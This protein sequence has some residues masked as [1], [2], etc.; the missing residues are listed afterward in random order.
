M[1]TQAEERVKSRLLKYLSRDKTGIRHAVLSL[2][3]TNN[4][5]TTQEI[6]NHLSENQFEITYRGVSAM[7]GLMNTRLGI[8]SINVSGDHNKYSLK[9]DHM[10]IVQ[11]VITET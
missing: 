3:L 1:L 2:F 6:Y 11:G 4:T 9:Y 5:F 7:V 10:G 8:L